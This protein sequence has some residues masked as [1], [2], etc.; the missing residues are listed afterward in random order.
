MG[1]TAFNLLITFIHDWHILIVV[2]LT[3]WL[4]NRNTKK[5]LR[6]HEKSVSEDFAKVRAD[7]AEIKAEVKFEKRVSQLERKLEGQQPAT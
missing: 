5:A 4:F 2:V 3:G 1:N 6:K 7:L